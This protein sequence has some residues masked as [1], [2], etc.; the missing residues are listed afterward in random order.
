LNVLVVDGRAHNVAA[1]A[2]EAIDTN[3]NR[4]ASSCAWIKLRRQ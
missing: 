3:L 1:N 4:H 2:A